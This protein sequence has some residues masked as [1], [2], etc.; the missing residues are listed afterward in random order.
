MSGT[1][2]MAGGEIKKLYSGKGKASGMPQVE[3]VGIGGAA[4]GLSKSTA[5]H[6]VIWGSIF[7]FLWFLLSLKT[8]KYLG[9]WQ[10]L[11]QSRPF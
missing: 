1:D 4:S 3:V 11:T 5:S 8:G 7:V 6:V 10:S 2:S 9:S